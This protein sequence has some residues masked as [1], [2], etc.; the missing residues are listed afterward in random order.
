MEIFSHYRIPFEI[1][2]GVNILDQPLIIQLLIL[3]RLIINFEVVE[4]TDFYL[5]KFYGNHGLS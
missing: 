4:K 5:E 2:G 3:W 1:E